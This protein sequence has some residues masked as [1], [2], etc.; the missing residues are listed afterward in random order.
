MGWVGGGA[1]PSPLHLMRR[2]PAGN[3]WPQVHCVRHWDGLPSGRGCAGK[4][5][6]CKRQHLICNFLDA[7]FCT[8]LHCFFDEL[9]EKENS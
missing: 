5:S 6:K 2:N 1:W 9:I 7:L 4:C 8:V 3:L